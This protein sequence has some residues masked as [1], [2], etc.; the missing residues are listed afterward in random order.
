MLVP[1]YDPSAT[2]ST[3]Y[4]STTPEAQ[5]WA[6]GFWPRPYRQYQKIWL[7]PLS[8]LP[9]SSL[10][11]MKMLFVTGKYSGIE[12]LHQSLMP[13]TLTGP[14]SVHLKWSQPRQP[15]GLI[16]H[17]RLI[18]K[19]HQQDPTLNSTAVTALTVEVN[20]HTHTHSQCW[21]RRTCISVRVSSLILVIF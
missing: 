18:Y 17:Y 15:N 2:S 21:I 8:Q 6:N 10:S 14:H 13:F 4:E 1:P 9:V 3:G 20:V 7:L 11:H 12:S 19:K 16:S 5:L